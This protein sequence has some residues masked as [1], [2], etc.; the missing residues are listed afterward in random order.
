MKS[1]TYEKLNQLLSE[2]SEERN[3]L[4]KEIDE[5]NSGIDEVRRLAKEIID[6]ED[7]DFKIFSPRKPEDIHK[8]ELEQFHEKE[9][10]LKK[11]NTRLIAER[12]KL[13]RIMDVLQL[14]S[15]ETEEQNLNHTDFS[16]KDFSG[17]SGSA[18]LL[19]DIKYKIDLCS[20]IMIQDSMRA[21]IE[22]DALS[23]TIEQ[24]ITSI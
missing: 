14:V 4:Q 11:Q 8:V 18:E 23:K 13:D 10:S 24:T 7:E 6:G 9:I 19:S 22:L 16:G 15:E 21:K 5:N 20:R 3:H 12:D 17:D 1:S 2:L